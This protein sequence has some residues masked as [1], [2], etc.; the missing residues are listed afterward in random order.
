VLTSTSRGGTAPQGHEAPGS[1]PSGDLRCPGPRSARR[2]RLGRARSRRGGAASGTSAPPALR[3]PVRRHDPQR[4]CGDRASALRHHRR[5]CR[6][7][8]VQRH[9]ATCGS[10]CGRLFV[11][12]RWMDDSAGHRVWRGDQHGVIHSCPQVCPQVVDNF[13]SLRC[14]WERC[15]PRLSTG[16]ARRTAAVAVSSAA[17]RLPSGVP[18][19]PRQQAASAL[20][21]P[22]LSC[23]A[24][25]PRTVGGGWLDGPSTTSRR[26]GRVS[27]DPLGR[28]GRA[29]TDVTG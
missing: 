4:R 20:R 1:T 23:S 2:I 18:P 27:G 22:V 17:G 25:G 19:S 24:V 13:R 28:G 10:P 7:T 29:D 26:A 3:V 6:D 5:V 9:A 15:L 21:P 8:P 16:S 14:R 11:H 12:T